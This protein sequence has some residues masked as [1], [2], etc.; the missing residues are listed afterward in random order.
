MNIDPRQRNT[1][2]LF[3]CMAVVP[4][5]LPFVG[6]LGLIVGHSHKEALVIALLALGGPFFAQTNI[7]NALQ[8]LLN[9]P[10]DAIIPPIGNLLGLIVAAWV[11]PGFV[12]FAAILAAFRFAAI[13]CAFLRLPCRRT[14]FRMLI[15]HMAD[16]ARYLI[17][18]R[19]TWA[20][21]R[22]PC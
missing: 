22:P 14:S 4:L 20:P 12:T 11:S 17:A 6:A 8:V 5:S 13:G 9:K 7:T 10:G 1:V 21:T 2:G 16:G 19:S 3:A 18:D 15:T